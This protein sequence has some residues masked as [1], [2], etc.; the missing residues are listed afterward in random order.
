[1]ISFGRCE[2]EI[3][4]DIHYQKSYRHVN[5]GGNYGETE[6]LLSFNWPLSMK[7][8]M[9]KF[10]SPELEDSPASAVAVKLL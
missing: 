6:F 4:K 10:P 7:V 3:I 9:R 8:K 1:M 2:V 5:K